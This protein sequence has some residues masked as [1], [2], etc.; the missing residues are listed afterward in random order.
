M[1]E[2]L[3]IIIFIAGL[4][5]GAATIFLLRPGDA[6]RV[7]RLQSELTETA[8]AR[9]ALEA[10]LSAERAAG[11]EKIALL[12]EAQ[13]KLSNAFA[14]L[15]ADALRNNNQSF[16]QL[17][18][19]TLETYQQAAKGDLEKR[20]IAIDETLKPVRDSLEKVDAKIAE[21]EK[22]RTGAYA[23]LNEQVRALSEGQVA[24]RSETTNLV[25][26]LRSP[27]V[28]GRW[29]EI[30]LRRVVEMAG[31]QAHCDFFEQQT[32][33]TED[34]QLRPDMRVRLPGNKSIIVD[35]KTPLEAYLKAMDAPDDETRRNFMT[36][37]AQNVRTH[38]ASLAKKSYWSQFKDTPELVVMFLPGEVF[39]SAALEADPALIEAGIEQN[40]ILATPT[41]LIGLLRAV[42]YGWRQ[43]AI[44][45]EARAI[46]DLGRD[47]YKRLADLSGHF[48]DLGKGLGGAV[49]AFNKAVGSLES[50]VLVS[51]RKFK[52]LIS[53]T[54]ESNIEVL[55]PIEQLPR[56][57]Q[58]PEMVAV[59]DGLP[60]PMPETQAVEEEDGEAG[61]GEA[62]E[63]SR[64]AITDL[65]SAMP[66]PVFADANTPAS[67]KSAAGPT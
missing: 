50:R 16:L 3:P 25:K 58:A 53:V 65:S 8:S 55:E 17:A 44:A 66:E 31:M 30:Q 54:T 15:S 23:A 63:R 2:S 27:A 45:V 61:N 18:K 47:L 64:S 4:V 29:G 60:F 37:H 59:P 36:A 7:E 48:F 1:N 24:L 62:S 35:A 6:K 38:I 34:G 5:V 40:I 32:L 19:S 49:K 51:A 20:Q 42:Y 21:L 52:D 9:A 57:L 26:A 12:D 28:R 39:F 10:Q 13:Q 11:T 67:P 22:S 43:E 56:A 33:T 46:S 14:A 41:T